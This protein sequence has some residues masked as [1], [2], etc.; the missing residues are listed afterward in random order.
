ML[1]IGEFARRALCTL[2]M[3]LAKPGPQCSSVAAGFAGHARVAVGAAGHHGLGHAEDAAHA[4]DLVE[5]GDEMHLRGAG[6]G[7]TGIDA[8]G[9]QRA[10]EAFGA[11]H[12]R[13]RFCEQERETY[14]TRAQAPM[15][16]G[17]TQRD[18]WGGSKCRFW[19]ARGLARIPATRG[20]TRRVMNPETLAP[21]GFRST[22]VVCP[23][24]FPCDQRSAASRNK[25]EESLC[26]RETGRARG[27]AVTL[28]LHSCPAR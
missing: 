12:G 20:A 25:N 13:D 10:D 3:P 27:L 2:A 4:L 5:R 24:R 19:E 6:I 26:V 22:A 21:G 7:E 23:L 15:W 1:T 8:A 18:R 28:C 9:E 11:V 14:H 16:M 17:Q